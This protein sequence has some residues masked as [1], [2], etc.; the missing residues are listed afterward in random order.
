MALL[1]RDLKPYCAT[2]TADDDVISPVGGTVDRTIT[3]MFKDFAGLA[4]IVSSGAGDTSVVTL[5]YLDAARA[6]HTEAKTLTGQTPVA[7]VA[8]DIAYL[9]KAVNFGVTV[10]FALEAQAQDADAS[11]TVVAGTADDVTLPASAS[12]LDGAYVN[13]VLRLNDN[14]IR[15]CIAYNGTTK[16]AAVGKAWSPTPTGAN[17]IRVSKGMV[18]EVISGVTPVEVRRLLLNLPKNVSG[19]PVNR[20]DKFFFWNNSGVD[21]LTSAVVKLVNDPTGGNLS[22]A[23]ATAVND[24]VNN[25]GTRLVAPSGLTFDAADKSVPGGGTLAPGARIGVWIKLAVQDQNEP[26]NV[27]AALR[28]TGT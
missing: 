8:T 27:E 6:L 10:D 23:L 9:L 18:W 20:Y 7:L 16:L 11:G 26:F 5:T 22:F 15:R 25:G 3:P 2:F 13:Y 4:Q 19:S 12:A 28:L 24:A 1:P 17:T 21:S 14:Q